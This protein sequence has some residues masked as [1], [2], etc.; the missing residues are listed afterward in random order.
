LRPLADGRTVVEVFV[1]VHLDLT[2]ADRQMLLGWRDV[3]EWAG[4]R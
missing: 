3:V 4:A 2:D 1:L